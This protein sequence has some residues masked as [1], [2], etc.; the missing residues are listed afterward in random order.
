MTDTAA[1]TKSTPFNCYYNLDTATVRDAV[2]SFAPRMQGR[3]LEV[4]CGHSPY[5]NLVEPFVDRHVA[6]DCDHSASTANVVCDGAA[7]AF[8]A[9][10]FDSALCTQVLEHVRDPERVL[11]EIARVLRPGG[12]VLLTVPLNSGIH[13]APHDYFRFTEFGLR[14]LCSRA[15]LA[16]EVIAERGGRIANAA[17]SL[18]LVFEVD[19][20]P[21]RH[22]LAAVA[23]RAIRLLT[24]MIQ[25]W[26]LRLDRRFHKPGNPL[27]YVVLARKEAR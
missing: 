9:D 15:G 24:W 26:A 2:R 14:E 22:V 21:S 23:R 12:R 13:M 7:L 19:R 16:P 4:G 20:M 18:L 25:H 17:Q 1:L 10:A 6:S 8:R 11:K 3:L 5:K 27:G